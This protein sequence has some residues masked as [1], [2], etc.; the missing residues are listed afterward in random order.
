MS[1]V[2]EDNIIA[3]RFQLDHNCKM[4]QYSVF[5]NFTLAL[6]NM[7]PLFPLDGSHI[8]RNVM[9][10]KY[11]DTFAQIDRFAPFALLLLFL[12]GAIWVVIGPPISLLSQIVLGY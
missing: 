11:E 5:I 3:L 10:P 2:A 8:L 9:G 1:N 7:V 12:T 6:F 4:L